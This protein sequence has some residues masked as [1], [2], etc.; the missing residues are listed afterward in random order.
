MTQRSVYCKN[1]N[2]YILLTDLFH[3]PLRKSFI[4]S[5]KTDESNRKIITFLCPNCEIMEESTFFTSNL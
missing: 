5:R 2:S 1:C 3:T 4:I